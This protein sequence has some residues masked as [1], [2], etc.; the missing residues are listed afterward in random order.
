VEL[1]SLV[2]DE[3]GGERRTGKKIGSERERGG[4]PGS[5]ERERRNQGQMG[6]ATGNTA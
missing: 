5:E 2:G 3:G 6:V 1:H 4:N